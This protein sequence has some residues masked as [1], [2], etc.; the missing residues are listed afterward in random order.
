M[1]S[2]KIRPAP[3]Y[4]EY[5]SDMLANANYKMMSLAERGLLDTMRKECWVNHSIPS[6]KSQ[7]ALYLRCSLE[8]INS[9]LTTRVTSFF[10]EKEGW[11]TCTELENYRLSQLE[12]ERKISEGGRKG[13]KATQERIKTSQGGLQGSVKPL[14]G[15][16]MN[17]VEKKGDDKKLLGT[18][19]TEDAKEW[20]NVY[21]NAPDAI[22]YLK[23]SRG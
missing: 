20:G 5:A 16:E 10:Q 12:R 3:A 21:S 14:R 23:A 4:Q 13:G 15:D 7:L 8:E 18:V 1:S 17:R 2:K 9:F 11:F 22:T 19:L 6:D